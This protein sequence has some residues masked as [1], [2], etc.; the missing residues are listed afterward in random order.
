VFSLFLFYYF[1]LSN[2]GKSLSGADTDMD[3]DMARG[4]GWWLCVSKFD[5][6]MMNEY[7]NYFYLFR[8]YFQ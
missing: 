5:E 2:F 4:H 1:S 6:T 3:M 7:F 8:E